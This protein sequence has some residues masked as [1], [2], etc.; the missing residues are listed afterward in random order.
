M[1]WAVAVLNVFEGR[2]DEATLLLDEAEQMS[3]SG[4]DLTLAR[5]LCWARAWLSLLQGQPEQVVTSA[6]PLLGSPKGDLFIRLMLRE[7]VAR[8]SIELGDVRSAETVA[9]EIVE[10]ARDK[11]FTLLEAWTL[12]T[13]GCA[14]AGQGRSVE[15][16]EVFENAIELSRAMPEPLN[17]AIT[18]H[19]WGCMLVEAD[20]TAGAREQVGAALTLFWRLGAG[21]FIQRSERILVLLQS[22][23]ETQ[24]T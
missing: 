21:P 16:V 15:A 18:R 13:L 11:G 19:E 22:S 20:D 6:K 23:E 3:R 24:M 1:L 10:I 12:P 2:W 5:Q 8:A 7:R 14:L 4:H 17:E 9:R